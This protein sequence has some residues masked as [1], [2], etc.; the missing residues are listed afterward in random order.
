[1]STLNGVVL[2]VF[3]L[4]AAREAAAQQRTPT[5]LDVFTETVQ[6]AARV[7]T[8]RLGAEGGVADSSLVIRSA[9]AHKGGWLV[10]DVLTDDLVGRGFRVRVG[11]NPVGSD[12]ASLELSYRVLDM[13][14]AYPRQGRSHGMGRL[15]VQRDVSVRLSFQ[16]TDLATNH[17]RWIQEAEASRTGRFPHRLLSVVESKEYPFTHAAFEK[18][19][20][21]RYLEPVIVSGV[22]GGLVYLF[23][24]NR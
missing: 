6:E 13:G 18:K 8:D 3:G 21:T 23:Y 20:W 12:S 15:W 24:A 14:V 7:A 11:E 17:V 16:L 2:V 10:E 9:A 1:M 4:L 19:S 22:V 5:N